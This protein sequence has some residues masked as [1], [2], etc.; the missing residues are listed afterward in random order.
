MNERNG[1]LIRKYGVGVLIGVVVLLVILLWLLWS[2][3]QP[4]DFKQRI[5]FVELAA[6]VVGGTTLV[7]GLLLN[8][9]GQWINQRAQDENQKRQIANQEISLEQLEN[10]RKQLDLT[11]QEQI[12]E[13]FTRAIEHLGDDKTEIRLGGMSALKQLADQEF[14]SQEQSSDRSWQIMEILTA[15][16]RER[17]QYKSTRRGEEGDDD[18]QAAL[19]LIGDLTER[20]GTHRG[21]RYLSLAT[22]DLM[23]LDLSNMHLQGTN[24]RNAHLE[25]ATLQQ[26]HLEGTD[27]GGTHLEGANLIEAHL[28]G[29][30]LHGAH[31][32]GAN[33]LGAKLAGA[34][35]GNADLLGAYFRSAEF[36]AARPTDG[37]EPPEW[38]TMLP[39]DKQEVLATQ[40]ENG[41]V[42]A[43][44]SQEKLKEINGDAS[45]I[46]PSDWSRSVW[47]STLSS[48]LPTPY[49]SLVPG[50]YHIKL[51]KIP[52]YFVV[53]EGWYSYLLGGLPDSFSLT[54][55]GEPTAGSVLEGHN[56]HSV[57]DPDKFRLATDTKKP[58]DYATALAK[59]INL[60]QWCLDLQQRGYLDIKREPEAVQLGIEVASGEVASGRQFE[61][62]VPLGKGTWR[63]MPG[64]FAPGIPVFPSVMSR[65]L[66]SVLFEG[67]I[68]QIIDLKVA[69]EIITIFT[70]SPESEFEDFRERTRN[71]LDTVRWLDLERQEA[72]GNENA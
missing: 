10:A 69:G 31:L 32:Q 18:I 47:W 52:M 54:L 70:S 16:V 61:V 23:S 68:C 34:T 25:G 39:R 51:G 33:L 14:G 53:D 66:P 2:F 55:A 57:V 7:G 44:V 71:V 22:A 30:N 13:R 59:P 46:L 27:L 19:N 36:V 50:E 20:Y 1:E 60:F 65:M 38:W 49:G 43:K 24:L 29:A 35:L 40:S 28:E 9:W 8:F 21:D 63:D 64:L 12:T 42:K 11:Q 41:L 37:E 5:A 17:A 6:T 58:R 26:A 3:V 62:S 67:D 15:Y 4:E 56:V 48:S 72:K 45:I